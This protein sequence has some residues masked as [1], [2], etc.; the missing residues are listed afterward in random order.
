ML[1]L[2]AAVLAYERVD[3][4]SEACDRKSGRSELRAAISETS[5]EKDMLAGSTMRRGV[6]RMAGEREGC[7]AGG[8]NSASG[9][10][11]PACLEIYGNGRWRRSTGRLAEGL[12]VSPRL[13]GHAT[14]ACNKLKIYNTT[15]ERKGKGRI[16]QLRP[17]SQFEGL[18]DAPSIFSASAEPSPRPIKC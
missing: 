12:D 3:R 13:S 6:Q 9:V 15:G 11:N 5:E 1:T 18:H 7:R 16:F 10:G 2:V 17:R 4:A 14:N 8:Y